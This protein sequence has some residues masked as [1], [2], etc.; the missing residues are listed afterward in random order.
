MIRKSIPF[1]LILMLILTNIAGV[2]MAEGDSNADVFE[3]NISKWT[4]AGDGKFGEKS[5]YYGK[6]GKFMSDQTVQYTYAISEMEV[7]SG[8]SFTF[9]VEFDV[10]NY[11][12]TGA[13]NGWCWQ[14]ILFGVQDETDPSGDSRISLVFQH[15]PEG[16]ESVSITASASGYS[17]NV[18]MPD[19][20]ISNMSHKVLI[21]YSIIDES[22]TVTVDGEEMFKIPKVKEEIQG[23]LG[24]GATWSCMRILKAVYTELDETPAPATP[25]P[26]PT[27]T[28]SITATPET[29]EKAH[30]SGSSNGVDSKMIIVIVLAVLVVIAI[31]AV[32]LVAIK[33]KK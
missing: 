3:S 29:T 6:D 2:L 15:Y 17:D 33:R 8:K 28:P 4:F 26:E 11:D 30:T 21:Y 25:T 13:A 19:E 24:F 16:Q 32:I 9:E 10:P 14:T 31:V 20:M 22:V 12:T 7:N 18:A 27:P 23:R 1:L 5:N